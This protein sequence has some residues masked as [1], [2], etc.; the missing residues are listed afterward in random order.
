[1]LKKTTADAHRAAQQRESIHD[2]QMESAN[3][4]KNELQQ[5]VM[6]GRAR[7]DALSIA[8]A[9]EKKKAENYEEQTRELAKKRNETKMLLEKIKKLQK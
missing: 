4:N 3:K 1:M 9:E 7:C 8:V 6:T 5:E 2:K